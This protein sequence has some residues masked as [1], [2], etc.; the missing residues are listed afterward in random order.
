MEF[1]S[2]H[3]EPMFTDDIVGSLKNG[4]CIEFFSVIHKFY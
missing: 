2:V 3:D 4:Q 1:C